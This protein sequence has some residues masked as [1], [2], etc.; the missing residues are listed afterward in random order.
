MFGF[1]KQLFL[2]C[3]LKANESNND[4]IKVQGG[5]GKSECVQG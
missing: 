1:Q 5:D 3:F 2:V 4:D